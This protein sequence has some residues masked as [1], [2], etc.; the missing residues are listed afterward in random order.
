MKRVY[1]V[2]F[3]E[4]AVP[5]FLAGLCILSFGIFIPF[6]GYYWDDWAKILVYRLQGLAY[7]WPYYVGDRPLSAWTHIVLT[8]LL[9]VKPISWQ[10]FTLGMRFLS[11]WGVYFLL[12]QL[13]PQNRFSAAIAAGIFSVYPLFSQQAI[14]VTFH[15]QWLQFALIIA[16]FNFMLFAIRDARH[17]TAWIV[18][19]ILLSMLQLSITEYFAPLE[20]L[21]P[22]LIWFILPSWPDWKK[23]FLQV[24]KH[25]LPYLLLIAAF[26]IIRVFFMP[27]PADDPYRAETLFNIFSKP[28]ETFSWLIKTLVV[29]LSY[30]FF[31]S[32]SQVF[33]TQLD[34]PLSLTFTT[35]FLGSIILGVGAAF[36]LMHL[37]SVSKEESQDDHW[38]TLAITIGLAAS[39][40]G[41]IPAWITQRQVLFDFHSDR[42]TLPALLGLSILCAGLINWLGRSKIQKAAL[43][44][45]IITLGCGY[46]LRTANDLRNN[47]DQQMRLYWQL[48]WRAPQ[49]KAPTAIF[50]ENE[51][52]PNQGLFSMSGALNQ[53]YPQHDHKDLLD[54]WFY[55]LRPKY[56]AGTPSTINISNNSTFRTLHFI[57]SSPNTLLLNLD[58]AHGNCLWVLRPEDQL[59]PYLSELTQAMVPMSNLNRIEGETAP[60]YPP[61]ELF[62]VEP[63]HDWCYA[64]E[65]AELAW[66]EQ[67]WPAIV[68]IG[69][70]LL[71]KGYSPKAAISNSP[72]EWWS[73]IVGYAHENQV[74]QAI[75]LS[76][77]SLKQDKKYHEAICNLWLT[78]QNVPEVGVGISELGCT[79]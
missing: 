30:I 32:W 29:D 26:F 4:W 55:T 50:S 66:Q 16:S 41:P 15:Q 45:L 53:L 31:G 9:G 77:Q 72:R 28:A 40:L 43:A 8:P 61:Q 56:N 25:W 18:V 62:G 44:G 52:I 27:L 17:R 24:V 73:F 11:A 76:Q 39:L 22:F 23:K 49:L 69:N 19:S 78:M 54:Y 21:R 3:P 74:R 37:S 71:A 36:F 2:V 7:Y 38:S 47:W 6:L 63:S 64:F 48:S 34:N 67:D 51:L 33:Q 35:I 12:I 57:G 70:D 68:L 42:Y 65:K 79:K 20:L 75:D 13:R 1:K 46:Q 60:G 14:S 59:N 58:P 5:L 10:I